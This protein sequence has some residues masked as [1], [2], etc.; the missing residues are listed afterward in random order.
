MTKLI[1]I[2][3]NSGSGKTTIAQKL[4]HTLGTGVMLVGQDDIRRNMLN[5]SD[6]PNNLAI[7][8]IEDIVNYGIAHCD[9]VILEGILNSA[10]YGSMI[11][12]LMNQINVDAYAY[13]FKLLFHETVRRHH[14]KD[15]TDFGEE[16]MMR[17]FVENDILKVNQETY[18]Y[19]EM[20]ENEIIRKILEDII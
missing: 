10:K 13:Y 18:L 3:G 9:Y 7:Q 15:E 19:Q 14:L 20:S 8:L 17:W 4:Q 12:R 5:V 2:R 16:A 6:Q 1:I 11:E